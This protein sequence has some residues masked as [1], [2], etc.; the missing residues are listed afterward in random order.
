MYRNEPREGTLE[1]PEIKAQ[2]LLTGGGHQV[3]DQ[4]ETDDEGKKMLQLYAFKQRPPVPH[5]S[6]YTLTTSL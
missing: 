1:R 6:Y 4:V 5:F 3:D 2:S